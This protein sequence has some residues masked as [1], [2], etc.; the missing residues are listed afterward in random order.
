MMSEPDYPVDIPQDGPGEPTP[1]IDPEDTLELD[2]D[3]PG[4]DDDDDGAGQESDDG[5]PVG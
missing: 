3:I 1:D 4:A 5:S 2:D